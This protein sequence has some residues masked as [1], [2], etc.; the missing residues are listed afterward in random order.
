MS[1]I[2]NKFE[3]EEED[4][5]KSIESL[6]FNDLLSLACDESSL[7]VRFELELSIKL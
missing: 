6:K 7:N 5:D 3:E 4:D 1:C 2:D